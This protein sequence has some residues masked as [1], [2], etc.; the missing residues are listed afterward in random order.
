MN[1]AALR[2]MEVQV[3]PHSRRSAPTPRLRQTVVAHLA[4]RARQHDRVFGED[5]PPS[6]EGLIESQAYLGK[7]GLVTRHG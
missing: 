5:K 3:G 6:D 2:M 4:L 7:L 1:E